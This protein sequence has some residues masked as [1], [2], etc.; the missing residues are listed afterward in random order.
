RRGRTWRIFDRQATRSAA[1]AEGDGAHEE[2]VDVDVAGLAGHV[3]AAVELQRGG[4][5]LL[6][7]E[8]ITGVPGD[9]EKTGDVTGRQGQQFAGDL[10]VGG[11]GGEEGFGGGDGNG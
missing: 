5:P 1:H 7:V 3:L 8:F 4:V 11:G 2:I 9:G 6:L 10:R